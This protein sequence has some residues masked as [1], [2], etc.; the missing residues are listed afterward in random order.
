MKLKKRHL[1][2]IIS[3]AFILLIFQVFM[4]ENKLALRIHLQD[5]DY[6]NEIE[7]IKIKN[8]LN[9]IGL[10]TG[11][12]GHANATFLLDKQYLKNWL[13]SSNF[14]MVSFIDSKLKKRIFITQKNK[15]PLN[16]LEGSMDFSFQYL[17]S[18]D[19]RTVLN[20]KQMNGHKQLK[21]NLYY[22]AT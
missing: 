18:N 10:L 6:P 3:F 14:E 12:D 15:L 21:I 2:A 9:I 7:S 5:C 19:E 8:R 17:H 20:V 1:L 13:L 16:L 11:N 22:T 4:F